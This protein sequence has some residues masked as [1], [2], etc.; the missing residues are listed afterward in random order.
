MLIKNVWMTEHD[1]II[2]L[3]FCYL[4]GNTKIYIRIT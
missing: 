2:G 3:V 4:T 1:A